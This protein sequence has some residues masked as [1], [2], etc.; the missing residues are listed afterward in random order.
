MAAAGRVTRFCCRILWEKEIFRA[1]L[2][3]AEVRRGIS[4]RRQDLEE[5][6]PEDLAVYQNYLAFIGEHP[7]LG[8]KQV[9]L[10]STERC[11]GCGLCAQVC[12]G[13]CIEIQDGRAVHTDD[14]CQVCL[15]C[16]HH[17][18]Q[19]AVRLSVPEVNPNARYIHPQISIREII[20]AN[21]KTV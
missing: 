9:K 13:N 14:N 7:E 1:D 17:C 21:Q 20:Q 2:Q 4:N 6:K 19:N 3:T 18:P 11:N 10:H 5:T 16:I 15:A 12:P 8:W